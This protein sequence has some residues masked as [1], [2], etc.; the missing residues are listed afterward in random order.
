MQ[1]GDA[2]DINAVAFRAQTPVDPA[3][4]LAFHPAW[5]TGDLAGAK[6]DLVVAHG[7][8]AGSGL[9]YIGAFRFRR[10]PTWFPTG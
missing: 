7:V 1:R 8:A 4:S 10:S 2:G 9:E 3:V 5:R 6:L